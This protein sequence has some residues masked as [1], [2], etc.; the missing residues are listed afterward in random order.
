MCRSKIGYF[1]YIDG[2]S[3]GYVRLNSLEDSNFIKRDLANKKIESL[4]L[5]SVKQLSD[6]EVEEYMNNV[7]K[8]KKRIYQTQLFLKFSN[9]I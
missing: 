4:Q 1:D 3:E 7:R 5:I 8:S 9:K 2:N 6:S